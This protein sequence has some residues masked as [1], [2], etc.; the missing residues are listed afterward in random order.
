M[1]DV[2]QYQYMTTAT[3]DKGAHKR[4]KAWQKKYTMHLNDQKVLYL[5]MNKYY[6][7]EVSMEKGRS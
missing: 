2:P 3:F 5:T 7:D 4:K 6:E 1:Y